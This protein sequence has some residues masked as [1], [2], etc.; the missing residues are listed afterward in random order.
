MSNTALLKI[1]KTQFELAFTMLEKILETCPDDLWYEKKGGYVFWQQLLHTLTGINFWFRQN[2]VKF[3]E[4][5]EDKK[6]YPE[7]ENEPEHQITRKDLIEYKNAVKDLIN[8]F[9]AHKDDKWLHDNSILFDKIKNI[10][11]IFMQV[12][13][14]QYHVGYCNCILRENNSE[15]VEWIDYYGE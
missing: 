2:N 6:V 7:L 8:T 5:F 9:F 15:T 10:D 3:V 13:H 12:R 4:P 14:I 1:T 11:V